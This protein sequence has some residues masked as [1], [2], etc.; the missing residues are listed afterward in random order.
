MSILN[1]IQRI[2]TLMESDEE[3]VECSRFNDRDQYK[4]C[5]RISSLKGWLH[6]DLGLKDIINNK[7]EELTT[8]I[9]NEL[10]D[11]FIR[12]AE[13]LQRL[14]KITQNQKESFIN[15]RVNGGKLI[16]L[17]GE[18]QSIN[19]LNTNY[20]DL[21]ELLTDLLYMGGDAAKKY[22]I[23]IN[24]NPKEGL[25]SLKPYL[26]G[27]INR[28]FQ[29][30]L[31][32]KDY[33]KNINRTTAQGEIAE[34]EVKNTLEKIGFKSE[35]EGGNGDLID[36]VFGTDLIM[37]RSDVGTKTIQVKKSEWA[38]NRN[39]AYPFIDW[40]IIANPFTI[41]NNKTKETISL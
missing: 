14:G 5:K 40:V 20:S 33:T 30:P 12:G 18:W 15:K 22:I 23:N 9:P 24:E 19:K 16:Y 38:W 28:Y 29:D 4:T 26:K 37:T 25:L 6:K 32:L 31:I 21:S 34:Q 7:L 36:M 27:L 11:N 3:Y 1:E 2:R 8:E 13:I 17:D 39:D 10:K 41:Y 35:Y